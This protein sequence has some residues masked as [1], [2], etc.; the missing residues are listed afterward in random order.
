[1]KLKKKFIAHDTGSGVV[2]VP[3]AKAGFAGVVQGNETLGAVLELLQAD[4]D[5]A[6]IVAA[7]R[8]RFD[9]P[10][11]TV[12]DDVHHALEGLRGIGAL[13]E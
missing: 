12:A 8:K 4:T 5:E 10:E 3:T 13:E 2:L 1:M 11:K 6:S 7:L 9:A